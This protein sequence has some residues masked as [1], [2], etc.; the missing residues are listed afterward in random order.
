MSKRDK[1]HALQAQIMGLEKQ[2]RETRNEMRLRITF[3]VSAKGM[4]ECPEYEEAEKIG[5]AFIAFAKAKYDW[6][7]EAF[8]IR[9][10]TR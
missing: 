1:I 6:K 4:T 7:G 5:K 10:V 2:I 9:D 8:F 3:E